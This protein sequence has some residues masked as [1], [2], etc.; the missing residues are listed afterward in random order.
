[1][2]SYNQP[3]AS[4]TLLPAPEPS[5]TTPA[6]HMTGHET[7][8]WDEEG[9]GKSSAA[10]LS[11]RTSKWNARWRVWRD[12]FEQSIGPKVRRYWQLYRN[13][14]YT[15]SPG[16]RQGW[17]DRTV[18][19]TCYKIIET[20]LPRLVMGQFGAREWFTVE[21]RDARDENYE[22]MVRVV[23]KVKIDQ[24]GNR[25]YSDG[26]F[27]KRAIDGMRY[28]QIMGHAWFKAWWRKESRWL[29]TQI[30]MYDEDGKIIDWQPVEVEDP[31]Y[32]N[33]DVTWMG[34]D[35]LAVDLHYGHGR[36]WAIERVRTSLEA[37][38]ADDKEHYRKTGV[39]LYNE[40]ALNQLEHGN[41]PINQDSYEEP[42]DTEHWPLDQEMVK[43]GIG[44]TDVE[45]WLCWDNQEMTLTKIANRTVELDHGLS[46]TPDGIDP[47]IGLMAI[48]IPGRVY[49]ESYLH[50]VGPLAAYQTRLARAR[51][52]EIMLNIWQQFVFR[53]GAVRSSQ[54]VFLPGGAMEVEQDE[55][56]RPISDNIMVLPRRPVMQEAWTEEAARQQQAEAAAAAD[57]VTQ[58]TEATQKSRD[59]SATEIQQRI[60]QGASR[61]Q[62]ENL[63]LAV[64][65]KK[66]LL[67]KIYDLIRQNM[68]TAQTVRVFNQ[69]VTVDLRNLDRPV[70]IVI[71]GGL[72]EQTKAEKMQEVEKSIQLAESQVF[73]PWLKP[74]DILIEMYRNN[75][76]RKDPE[77][78]VKSEEEM[79]NA[80]QPQMAGQQMG[81]MA[82]DK[83]GQAAAVNPPKG[84]SPGPGGLTGA[85]GES[86][87]A[88]PGR[89]E[90][91]VEEL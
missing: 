75:F 2:R 16:P 64:S 57:A 31:I 35:S 62:M 33:V 55:P 5:R 25:D 90:P 28:A 23:L 82:K 32:D 81:S 65:F 15:P 3:P 53:E 85:T 7:Y 17:R 21:G 26:G 37:L 24:I 44:E 19:P 83:T 13:F 8:Y 74:R 20:R 38:K 34:L 72:F 27:I 51:A 48:P 41:A 63:Y 68:T 56:N 59:V 80:L 42:R 18:I 54:F 76:D 1:M 50:Y 40:E 10:P 52:D 39:H 29:K 49:G 91:V 86:P 9:T 77:K 46:P 11:N 84:A 22:E 73:G 12:G 78:F 30:P 45:L 67:G 69:D 58:G 89:S 4:G 36:R 87:P 79:K 88:P 66:P 47:Y 70:D 43:S 71:G 60:M 14:D 6:A 61:Y